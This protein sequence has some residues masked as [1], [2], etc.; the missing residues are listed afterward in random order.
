M[1]AKHYALSV[2]VMAA[3][4]AS[5]ATIGK[6]VVNQ[7]WPWSTKVAIDYE[8]TCD[9]GETWDVSLTVKDAQDNEITGLS[10]AIYGDTDNVAGGAHRLVWDPG[11]SLATGTAP[12]LSYTLSLREP[13]GKKYMIVDLTRDG[14]GK[15]SVSYLDEEPSG[16]FNTE[17]YTTSKIVFRRC[18]AGSFIMGSPDTEVG[19]DYYDANNSVLT[20]SEKQRKVTLTKD[21][22]LG[23][24][25]LT[26]Y[27]TH[28]LW[29]EYY[30]YTDRNKELSYGKKYALREIRPCHFRNATNALD[31]AVDWASSTSVDPT[32]LIGQL[33][34]GIPA[35]AQIPAGYVFDLP[36]EAQWEYACRAGTTNVW[37]NDGSW[38][39]A[40]SYGHGGN[41]LAERELNVNTGKNADTVLR[42]L[43]KYRY[44][45]NETT[46]HFEWDQSQSVIVG[47]FLPNA[48]GFYDMHGNVSELCV[49][50]WLNSGFDGSDMVDPL[51][52]AGA[53][54]RLVV[55]GGSWLSNA[56]ECRSAARACSYSHTAVVDLGQGARLARVPVRPA[57]E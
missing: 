7:M 48:W 33:R 47:R 54:G 43:G 27:Q 37:N 36:T 12:V 30:A 44:D 19:H 23:I 35:E 17:E 46:G 18:R 42:F 29:P 20:G 38:S 32:S 11:R 16:G 9:P 2:A 45:Y 14:E 4:A 25:E 40:D 22:Y 5:A 28:A 56:R 3:T 24:F 53:T 10:N 41:T 57:G 55:R 26:V 50:R 6:V 15:F 52:G 49:D 51:R 31:T 21:F 1:N 13:L 8:L 39:P 34:A